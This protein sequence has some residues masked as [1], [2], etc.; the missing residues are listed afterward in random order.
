MSSGVEYGNR[1]NYFPAA[2]MQPF[3]AKSQETNF[4]LRLIPT[5]QLQIEETYLYIRLADDGR[6]TLR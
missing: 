4:T 5:P 6:G 3:L 2:G 1:I